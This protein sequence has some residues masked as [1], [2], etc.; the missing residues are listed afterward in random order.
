MEL[1]LY[2]K[3][4]GYYNTKDPFGA[5]GDFVTAPEISQMFGELIGAWCFEVWNRLGTPSTV[6]LIELGPGQG[7]LM[8]DLLRTINLDPTFMKAID[9]HLV[10]TSPKL[11]D[12]QQNILKKHNIPMTWHHHI[13]EVPENPS[14]IIANEFFDA[15]PIQQYIHDSGD[16]YEQIVQTNDLNKLTIGI[17]SQPTQ[18]SESTKQVSTIKSG[19][20]VEVANSSL[21]YL[22]QICEKLE[23][24][25]SAC[26]LI[27][28][29]YL[30]FGVGDSLQAVKN[31]QFVDIFETPGESDLTAHVNFAALLNHAGNFNIST[32]GPITQ[33]NFL[34]KLGIL[35]R[36]GKLGE[37]KNIK[38]QRKIQNDVNRLVAPE[39]M[40][41]L[42][43]V[44][45][46]T[47]HEIALP[48]FSQ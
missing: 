34:L 8:S 32:H 37:G 31:H 36:A 1:C 40:G 4:F 9:L 13:T 12:L 5:K 7:T 6:N 48:G 10:E 19:D 2:D 47:S 25:N 44:V 20:V 30:N 27:D 45:A 22:S 33:Q 41:T 21:S 29:G 15:F 39:H 23:T 35:E 16:W 26:L 17:K 18:I 24:H 46:L 38:L 43:K 42:F 14:I 3:E 11:S 28:Y